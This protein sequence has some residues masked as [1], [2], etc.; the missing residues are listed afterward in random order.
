MSDAPERIWAMASPNDHHNPA[1]EDWD[2]GSWVSEGQGLELDAGCGVEYVRTDR[3]EELVNAVE[4]LLSVHAR[5]MS[6]TH[7]R[8]NDNTLHG[9]ALRA[10]ERARAALR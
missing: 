1:T 2:F 10:G 7:W 5:I 8:T 9:D 3:I 4:G 6:D